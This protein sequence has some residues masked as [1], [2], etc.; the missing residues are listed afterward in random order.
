VRGEHKNGL[1]APEWT[2][3]PADLVEKFTWENAPTR[4]GDVI[5]FDSFVPHRSQPNPTST[6]VGGA[7][8]SF[9]VTFICVL[10]CF[11]LLVVQV[12]L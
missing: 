8:A 3:V 11:A 6:P 1:L 4:S 7:N 12:L 10:F 5:F 2:A 9:D